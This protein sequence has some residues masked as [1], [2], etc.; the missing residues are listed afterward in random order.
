[1]ENYKN[2]VAVITGG[3]NGIGYG[4][5]EAFGRQGGKIIITDINTKWGRKKLLLSS[6]LLASRLHIFEHDVTK[7]DSWD[8]MIAAVKTKY[9]EG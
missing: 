3:A 1:M 6:R 8:A 5:A 7:E 9:S 4:V 2:K